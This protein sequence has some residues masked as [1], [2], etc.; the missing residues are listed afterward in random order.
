MSYRVCFAFLLLF[1]SILFADE[2]DI[3]LE[4][5]FEIEDQNTSFVVEKISPTEKDITYSLTGLAQS[6]NWYFET[7]FGDD[8]FGT[9]R[10][11][12][13]GEVRWRESLKAFLS[14][15]IDG[16]VYESDRLELLADLTDRET[17][18][19]LFNEAFIDVNLNKQLYVRVGKQ[20]LQWGRTFFW[21]PIDLVSVEEESFL[22]LGVELEGTK[23]VKITA[24][25]GNDKTIYLFVDTGDDFEDIAATIRFEW[26]LHDTE[27]GISLWAKE[28]TDPV[29]GFDFSTTINDFII[30]GETTFT[31]SARKQ[32]VRRVDPSIVEIFRENSSL[33]NQTSLNVT[34][35]WDWETTDRISLT[36]EFFYNSEGY[37][38]NVFEDPLLAAVLFANG[39]YEQN[40]HGKYYAA[41]FSSI[42]RFPFYDLKTYLNAITNLSDNSGI[43]NLGVEIPLTYNAKIELNGFEFFGSEPTE[44]RLFT[45]KHAINLNLIIEF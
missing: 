24:P 3:E 30:A 45:Q 33:I 40:Y 27:Y 37:D 18:E 6:R 35:L 26:L 25:I 11:N 12:L 2:L 9:Y 44:Y 31:T 19:H 7:D 15:E 38:E 43:I 42:Q 36:A 10:A 14:W 1:E 32:K 39:L 5:A 4:G 41:L 28:S 29:L 13:F 21:N 34:K 8:Y 16:D 17:T 20:T 22:D 23:G